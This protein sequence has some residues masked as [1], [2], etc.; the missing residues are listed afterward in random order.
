MIGNW[1][2]GSGVVAL[3]HWARANEF[4]LGLCV[5][6]LTLGIIVLVLRTPRQ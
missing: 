4:P 2:F 5:S 3:V 1:Q 6:L